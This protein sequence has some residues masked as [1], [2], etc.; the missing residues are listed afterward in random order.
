MRKKRRDTIIRRTLT[1]LLVVF[2]VAKVS[3]LI[4][5]PWWIVAA[6]LWMRLGV[7][8]V[9]MITQGFKIRA[10]LKQ[11]RE[12]GFCM[13]CKYAEGRDENYGLPLYCRLHDKDV[14]EESSC[15]LFKVEELEQ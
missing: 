14:Q 13:D 10:E 7:A 5:W 3:G 2:V 8:A 6:P 11:R 12:D 4:A 9:M 1:T 15:R